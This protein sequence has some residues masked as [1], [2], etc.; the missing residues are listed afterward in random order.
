MQPRA[1]D[2]IVHQYIEL[3]KM[4]VSIQSLAKEHVSP[5]ISSGTVTKSHLIRAVF[6]VPELSPLLKL[7]DA[8]LA[9]VWRCA[10]SLIS[11]LFDQE[12]ARQKSGRVLT[13]GRPRILSD[14]TEAQLAAR[15][16][17]RCKQQTWPT[18]AAFESEVLACLHRE[19]RLNAQQSVFL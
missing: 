17:E 13:K 9:S 11:K 5:I 6:N 12:H 1:I 10:P 4:P 14:E 18:L 19:P 3:D 7:P 8:T 15:V 2:E 16:R